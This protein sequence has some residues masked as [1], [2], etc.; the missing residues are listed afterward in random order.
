MT[1]QSR[2]MTAVFALVGEAGRP[3]A[4]PELPDRRGYDA[5]RIDGRS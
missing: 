1:K 2:K 3:A 4:S 5:A